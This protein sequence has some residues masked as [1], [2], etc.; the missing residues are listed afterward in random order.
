MSQGG[1]RELSKH[2][3]SRTWSAPQLDQVREHSTGGPGVHDFITAF[4]KTYAARLKP[5]TWRDYRSILIRHLSHFP[6]F[7]D[8]N[9]GL[10]DYLADLEASGKRKNN[11]L[12]AARCFVAWARRRE[13]WG[14]NFYQVPRFPHRSRKTPPLNPEEAR[15]VMDYSPQPYRDF[16][17]LSILSGMRTG[18]HW[19]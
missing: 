12:S 19:A 18:K 15:L 14:G 8:L 2:L 13:L 1:P 11:I 7:D 4:L 16:L 6:T 5:S 3:S 9:L 17:R 10:E